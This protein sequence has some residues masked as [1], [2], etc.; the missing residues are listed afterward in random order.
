M[1]MVLRTP[2]SKNFAASKIFKED[3]G[4]AERQD[5]DEDYIVWKKLRN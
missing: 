5:N 2:T 4:F 1:L 3:F